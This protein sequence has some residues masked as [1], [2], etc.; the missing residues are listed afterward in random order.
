MSIRETVARLVRENAGGSYYWKKGDIVTHPKGYK[1]RIDNGC[2]LDPTYGRVS[3]FW[4]WT[5]CD[6]KGN[7]VGKQEHGYGW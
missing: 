1:V 7:P 5:P 6:N 4:Y 2:Y 3:N